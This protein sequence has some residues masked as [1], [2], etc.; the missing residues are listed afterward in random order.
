MEREDR[1]TL[2]HVLFAYERLWIEAMKYK[3]LTDHPGGDPNKIQERLVDK[4]HSLFHP[5]IHALQNDT[6]LQ[7]LAQELLRTVDRPI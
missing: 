3:Y 1:E 2:V 6:P 7:G 4:A 5:L